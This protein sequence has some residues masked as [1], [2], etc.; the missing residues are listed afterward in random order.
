[1]VSVKDRHSLQGRSLRIDPDRARDADVA[2]AERFEDSRPD[3]RYE[4]AAT[5]SRSS[6]RQFGARPQYRM[7]SVRLVS[8][9]R[10][11]F[12][13]VVAVVGFGQGVFTVTFAAPNNIVWKLGTRTATASSNSTRCAT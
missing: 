2:S 13:G 1:M 3:R 10:K 8:R 4:R 5:P 12:I 7:R 6:T 11:V 9:R